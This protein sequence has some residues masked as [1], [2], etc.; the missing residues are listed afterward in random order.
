MSAI[1]GALRADLSASVGKFADDMGKAAQEVQK[2]GKKAARVGRDLSAA[3]RSLTTGLTL[4]LLALGAGAIKVS[5]DFEKAMT[6]V[7]IST[8]ATTAEMALL[9]AQA[10]AIGKSTVFSAEEAAQAIDMLAKNGL[11]VTDILGGAAEAATNLAAAA[12]SELEPAAAAVT[13]AMSQFKIE[14]A[15]LPAAVN[16][17]TGAVN[18]SKLSFEDFT[19]A[20]G[21][22]GGVAGALGVSFEDFNAT[23]AATS[24]LFSSGSD[25]GTS[26]KTFLQ[27]LVPTT[28][29]AATA[30]RAANLEFFNADGSMKSMTDIAEQ[31]RVGLGGLSDEAKNEALKDI[32]GTDAMRTAIGLMD[33]GAA[34][35][36][37]VKDA[38]AATDAQ[39][40]AAKRMEGL[41]GQLEQ[42]KGAAEELGIAIGDSGLLEFITGLVVGAADFI[43]KLSALNP[44]ILKWA[45]VLGGIVAVVGPVLM[46]LGAMASGISAIIAILPLIT[47]AIGFL[48]TAILGPIGLV[49]AAIVGLGIV[50]AVW[51]D[52]ITR[53]VKAAID[54]FPLLYR[55]VK[56]WLV[57]KMAG[58]LVFVGKKVVAFI[59]PFR[60]LYDAV[61]GH[62]WIPDMVTEVGDWMSQ[63]PARMG[64]PTD[65]AVKR[66]EDGFRGLAESISSELAN[67]EL[68]QATEQANGF[69]QKLADLAKEAREAGAS[70][71]A[72]A[73]AVRVLNTQID[74]F[75]QAGLSEEA[76]DF[77]RETERSARAV[78][79]FARG[80]LPPLAARLEEV[81]DKYEQLRTRIQDAIDE[82]RVLAETNE[83]ARA[84][85]VS[86]EAQLVDLAAAHGQ[87]TAAA[88]A[89][90]EAEEAIANLR[91]QREAQ[92]IQGDIAE[93]Q[94]A[95]GGSASNRQDER[96]QIQEQL[97]R[98]RIDA[99]IKLAEM[100]AARTEAVMAGDQAEAQRLAGLITLQRE[101]YD[102]VTATT[103]NQIQSAREI[104]SAF[105]S[106]TDSLS[107]DLDDMI[108]DLDFS[109]DGFKDT[110][111]QLI[112]DLFKPAR[113]EAASAVSGLLKSG[114][115][116]IM[117]RF[118]G[119]FATGG[120]IP[121]GHWGIAGER[122]PEPIFA[123][124]KPVQ[125]TSN[126]DAFAAAGGERSGGPMIMIDAR[127]AGKREI[128]ELKGVLDRMDRTFETRVVQASNDG[129]MR[130][131]IKPPSFG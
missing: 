111:R 61:V 81:D 50:W 34:G 109:L 112:S 26:F 74:R 98:Q 125:V 59:E 77:A 79:D 90:Y 14:A 115:K 1:I 39:A 27:R 107:D 103:A 70:T 129:L 40:Q 18:E 127:G 102:I 113:D 119:G 130:G 76:A 72:V 6:E 121:A 10:R 92:D 75:E 126:G 69:R 60:K 123:G 4:P 5:M 17:I 86:L 54:V 71:Q 37:R 20:S 78:R 91:A 68:P 42:L 28:T 44:E 64:K 48:W 116:A 87:A 13:D 58:L 95:A 53:I 65:E 56:A 94:R 62:S 82:N 105:D 80:G 83:A 47:A 7:S 3:G 16:Q 88:R 52:D 23:L 84:T 63:L 41:S 85:M 32:F 45:V 57:D 25:A 49:I 9:E 38:I 15:D 97:D 128:D 96:R 2:F 29:A 124:S 100:E 104:D 89:Q 31:L 106:F 22:A 110:F 43:D 101:Y 55:A 19:L 114:V 11:G 51:G 131:K 46:F 12:G 21:Q 120:T 73:Q 122:G 99:Q 67:M 24:P 118:A 117:G 35:L 66:V 108:M 8:Q 93:A 33:Q 30:I 36:T